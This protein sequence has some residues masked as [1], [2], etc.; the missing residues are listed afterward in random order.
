MTRQ[1]RH[2]TL[3]LSIPPLTS[4]FC[5]VPLYT[6]TARIYTIKKSRSTKLQCAYVKMKQPFLNIFGVRVCVCVCVCTMCTY[7]QVYVYENEYAQ[8]KVTRQPKFTSCYLSP[9]SPPCPP[10][11][12]S[13]SFSSPSLA[14]AHA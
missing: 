2:R 10:F 1:C 5:R 4:S 12:P 3:S 6:C 9:P 11:R 14:C 8:G 7:V 13:P